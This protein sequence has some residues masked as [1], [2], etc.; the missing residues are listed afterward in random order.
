MSGGRFLLL[1]MTA[2][3]DSQV[4]LIIFRRVFIMIDFFL[5][6]PGL[7]QL[8]WVCLIIGGVPTILKA[9]Q[10]AWDM[11]I[12]IKVILFMGCVALLISYYAFS[13]T[14]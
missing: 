4:D 5:H 7:V 10:E 12:V 13:N 8:G 3:I 2:C 6:A 9:K 14:T 1:L 11:D